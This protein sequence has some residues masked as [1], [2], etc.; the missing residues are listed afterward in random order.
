MRHK[1]GYVETRIVVVFADTDIDFFAVGFI[2]DAVE[3][4]RKRRPLI[5]FKSAVIVCFEIADSGAFKK[6]KLLQVKTR[7]INVC[8][9]ETHTVFQTTAAYSGVKNR[10]TVVNI[11]QFL[12]AADRAG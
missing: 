11:I 8:D 5:F 4:Q 9:D 6:R 2:Y 7:R 12:A 1:V 3:R 10:F